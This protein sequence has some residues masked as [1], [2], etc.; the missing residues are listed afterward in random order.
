MGLYETIVS[1]KGV[2]EVLDIKYRAEFKHAFTDCGCL[3]RAFPKA[4]QGFQEKEPASQGICNFSFKMFKVR[5]FKMLKMF[6]N[7]MQFTKAAC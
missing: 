6:K 1:S 4:L 5:F 2:P 7:N 3:H